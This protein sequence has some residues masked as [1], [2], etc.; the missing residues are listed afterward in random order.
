MLEW[1]TELNVLEGKNW[2]LE[3]SG[4]CNQDIF[5]NL[6]ICKGCTR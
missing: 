4:E 2:I 3:N 5:G 1:N 6:E